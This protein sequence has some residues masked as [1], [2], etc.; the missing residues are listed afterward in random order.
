MSSAAIS[1]NISSKLPNILTEKS[2]VNMLL[3]ILSHYLSNLSKRFR[4]SFV[5]P[6]LIFIAVLVKKMHFRGT[7]LRPGHGHELF[8]YLFCALHPFLFVSYVLPVECLFQQ[9]TTLLYWVVA[10]R[11]FGWNCDAL[12]QCGYT[13]VWQNGRVPCPKCYALS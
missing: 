4:R 3:N 5:S 10:S 7:F 9:L 8:I 6:S 13:T 12:R 1:N 2:K 11:Q